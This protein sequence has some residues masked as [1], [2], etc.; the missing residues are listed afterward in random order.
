MAISVMFYGLGPIGAAVARQVASRKGFKIAGGIDI[1]S[2][3][4]GRDLGTGIEL[5]CKLRVKVTGDAA[6]E[7]KR[8]KPDVVAL[9]TNSALKQIVPQ[10]ETILKARVPIVSTT[11]ELSYP[12]GKKRALA[13][14]IDAMAQT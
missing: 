4:V 8:K 1:D 6:G 10:I 3:K 5:D 9:C 13:R 11:E 14:K 7:L 2:A 12:V